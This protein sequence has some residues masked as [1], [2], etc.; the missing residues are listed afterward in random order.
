MPYIFALIAA[1]SFSSGFGVSY[2]ISKAEIQHMSDGI[3]AQNREAEIQYANLAEQANKV[4]KQLEDANAAT[5]K[6]ITNQR[7][8]FKPKRMYDTH[9]KSSNCTAANTSSA[10]NPAADDGQL[11]DQLTGFLKSE[12]YR[13]D[14]ISAYALLCAQFIK[15][16]NHD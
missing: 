14:E 16:N 1:V 6:T 5:I 3:A 7:D 15:G 8:A 11:S 10:V 12:A 13:A 4:N 9:W 2:Q